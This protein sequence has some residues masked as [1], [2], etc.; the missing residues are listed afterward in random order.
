MLVSA[1]VCFA[2]AG[3]HAA[4]HEAKS[5]TNRIEGIVWD[6]AHRPVPD[7]YASIVVRRE[8]S[9]KILSLLETFEN[10]WVQPASAL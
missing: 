6:P 2:A 4:A 7:V 10:P 5:L 1:I 3:S 8:T 9:L